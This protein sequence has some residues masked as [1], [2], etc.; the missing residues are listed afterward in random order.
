MTSVQIVLGQDV[1]PQLTVPCTAIGRLR[2]SLTKG[3]LGEDLP[4]ASELVFWADGG[5]KPLQ[6]SARIPLPPDRL[7]VEGPLAV[8]RTLRRSLR[9]KLGPPEPVPEGT[10]LEA[11]QERLAQESVGPWEEVCRAVGASTA[12]LAFP[13]DA[14]EKWGERRTRRVLWLA[15]RPRPR[16]LPGMQPGRS[17]GH[18]SGSEAGS[19]PGDSGDVKDG[20]ACGEEVDGWR[21]EAKVGHGHIGEVFRVR[22]T[23]SVTKVQV[24]QAALKWTLEPQELTTWKAIQREVPGFPGLPPL[25]DSGFHNGER[26]AVT[27]LLGK[28]CRWLLPHFQNRSR[29]QRWRAVRVLGRML[30]RRLQAVHRCGYVHCDVSPYNVLFGCAEQA[31]GTGREHW[32]GPA[33]VPYL[34]DF[35]LARP[36]PGKPLGAEHGTVEFVSIRSAAGGPRLPEDDLEALGWVM[37]FMVVGDLPWLGWEADMEEELSARRVLTSSTELQLRLALAE[38]VRQAKC[39]VL[40]G[41]KLDLPPELEAYIEACS[42]PDAKPVDPPDY[43]LLMG[44]LGGRGG[45]DPE[46]AECEDIME[47]RAHIVTLL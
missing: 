25:L 20:L 23:A 37:V 31:D 11:K 43:E 7:R 26:Y 19:D 18:D 3:L 12:G 9:Q 46:E 16:P 42:W 10:R 5:E 45:L 38:R 22:R 27:T 34:I 29:G 24:D 35:G 6:D 2:R 1:F 17:M 15:G 8:L 39:E 14:A 36:H 44:L 41:R 40:C 33:L 21:V 28:D 30:L 4:F 13:A 47:C 32:G